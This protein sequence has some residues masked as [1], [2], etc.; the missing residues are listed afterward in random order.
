MPVM[1]MSPSA[2]HHHPHHHGSFAHPAVASSSLSSASPSS[3]SC[4]S[5]ASASSVSLSAATTFLPKQ[6]YQ[7]ESYD[8]FDQLLA[9]LS[10]PTSFAMQNFNGQHLAAMP[11]HR[12]VMNDATVS[13]GAAASLAG[14]R[15]PPHHHSPQQLH[16]Q[17]QQQQAQQ[18]HYQ[19]YRNVGRLS[20]QPFL[21]SDPFKPAYNPSQQPTHSPHHEHELYLP[22]K[23]NSPARSAAALTPA[24]STHTHDDTPPA[25]AGQKRKGCTDEKPTKKKKRQPRRAADTDPNKPKRKT[26]LNKPLILSPA[27]SKFVGGETEVRQ[28]RKKKK[29][30]GEAKDICVR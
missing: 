9:D 6:A 15:Q 16:Y 3:S 18:Q 2:M 25:Y 1:M 27:L 19:A 12:Q 26:G 30:S 21:E 23:N 28:K 13:P 11:H 10:P 22:A 14:W 20:V 24:M 4:S 5:S 7:Q 17:Q 8:S 29:I